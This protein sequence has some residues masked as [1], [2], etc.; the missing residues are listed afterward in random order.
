M[1]KVTF[2]RR[3]VALGPLAIVPPVSGSRR[4]LEVEA[5][6]LLVR[7]EE[8]VE[9]ALP[10]G[11]PSSG[12]TYLPFIFVLSSVVLCPASELAG[13]VSASSATDSRARTS[14]DSNHL[15]WVPPSWAI[16]RTPTRG[17]AG[18][19]ATLPEITSSFP[20]GSPLELAAGATGADAAAAIGPRLAKDA[21]GIK[22]DG[23]LRDL[24]AELP[25]G[26]EIA[27]V[28][29]RSEGADGEDAL[30]LVRHDAAHVLATAVVEL[31]PGTKVSIGPP[32]DGGFY[33][34]FE[35]PD[36]ERPSEADL[37]RIEAAMREHIAADEPFERTRRAGRRGARA[38]PRRG[39]ALQGRADRG[40]GARRGGRD[41]LA[42][43]KR[44]VHR[45]LPRPAR[46][47]DRAD[48]RVQAELARRR[49]LAR[50][51]DT[52]RC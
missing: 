35:F 14:F 6:L 51:R 28:T 3:G 9:R 13:I 11:A 33:Y 24:G 19:I 52:A 21:L 50:R 29:A 15:R 40:P 25:D 17:T 39:R 16:A 5:E 47:V 10:F 1:K 31:W 7:L 32:I 41:R 38:L 8:D 42:V 37:E 36:G 49:L 34:D 43:P 30:W 20:D 27:I 23:E 26:A 12:T 22:V 2:D 4:S 45:P 48:R 18:S 44:A 46:A